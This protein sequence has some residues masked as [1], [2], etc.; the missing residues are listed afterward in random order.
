MKDYGDEEVLVVPSNV[1]ISWEGVET[2][3]K[4]KILEILGQNFSFVLRN[5]AEGNPE[6]RQIIS[7]CVLSHTDDK[8]VTRLF[9]ARR[10]AE[11]ADRELKGKW[12][13]GIGGH[14]NPED[15][16]SLRL[17]KR[18][19]EITD[20]FIDSHFLEI[21]FTCAEREISEEVEINGK[22]KLDWRDV[23]RV[24][25]VG[26]L[27]SSEDL[28]SQDHLGVVLKLEMATQNVKVRETAELSRGGFFT[29]LEF[30]IFLDWTDF[31][32]S[33]HTTEEVERFLEGDREKTAEIRS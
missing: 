28:V 11:E 2:R 33:I 7:Y 3:H 9:Y 1:I 10:K 18:R 12:T 6:M 16:C 26:L 5:K 21:L 31:L 32:L 25:F 20:L 27:I 14:I 17:S 24:E 13:I 30:T 29:P 8:G 22:V 23:K 15:D 4:E 19:R